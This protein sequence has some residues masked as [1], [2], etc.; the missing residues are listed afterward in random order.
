MAKKTPRTPKAPQG[1][2]QG[3]QK[4]ATR[5][6]NKHSLSK[7][8]NGFRILGSALT[9]PDDASIALMHPA[10]M[11]QCQFRFEASVL[12]TS[13]SDITAV[14]HFRVVP[15]RAVTCGRICF[16]GAE[17]DAV[18]VVQTAPAPPALVSI[19]I[20]SAWTDDYYKRYVHWTLRQRVVTQGQVLVV[21]RNMDEVAL[22]LTAP[23]HPGPAVITHDTRVILVSDAS[24]APLDPDYIGDIE[25][26]V[27]LVRLTFTSA[28]LNPD[29]IPA[30]SVVH[31]LPGTGKTLISRHLAKLMGC[32]LL[33]VTNDQRHPAGLRQVLD[34]AIVQAPALVFIDEIDSLGSSESE[35]IVSM[36]PATKTQQVFIL[37]ATNRHDSVNSRL[38]TAI[39]SDFEVGVPSEETRGAML[40]HFLSNL[41]IVR[42][43]SGMLLVGPPGSGKARLARHVG[44][45]LG[46]EVRVLCGSA[47]VHSDNPCAMVLDFFRQAGR[48]VL[49]YISELEALCPVRSGDSDAESV[50]LTNTMLTSLQQS[51]LPVICGA[52]N[53]DDLDP[54]VRRFGRLD[55]EILIPPLTEEDRALV[56]QDMLGTLPLD[57]DVSA[58]VG[59][60]PGFLRGDLACLVR[61]AIAS[62]KHLTSS[63]LATRAA[64]VSPAAR[65]STF[66]LP[67]GLTFAA[68]AGYGSAIAQLKESVLLSTARR[69]AFK[70]MKL[71]PARGVMIHGANGVGKTYMATALA[72]ESGRTP[73]AIR[74]PDILS[75]FLGETERKLVKLF[76]AA[77]QAVPSVILIDEIDAIASSRSDRTGNLGTRILTT[78][79][80]LIDGVDSAADLLVVGTTSRPAVIDPAL[81]RSGRLGVTVHIGLPS[82][83]DL[84]DLCYYHLRPLS[85]TIE[86]LEPLCAEFAKAY[87]G[88]RCT[89]SDVKLYCQHVKEKLALSGRVE[90]VD[91]VT[92]VMASLT[93]SGTADAG[94]IAMSAEFESGKG[95]DTSW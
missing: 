62:G 38:R 25:D 24:P 2:F 69:A 17:D 5:T 61:D 95:G 52:T 32:A 51:R 81:R 19:S 9:R 57:G 49:L 41:T 83:E 53:S 88:T 82:E 13:S 42:P 64:K 80:T 75:P 12:I 33:T 44:M 21:P 11:M 22:T 20:V 45:T 76:K 68:V 8:G 63:A 90:T 29:F 92:E 31:G 16:P 7:V 73:F 3:P 10:D 86:G 89:A 15:D 59:A 35:E 79:L 6:P 30:G 65:W 40:D 77:R 70:T 84:R 46:L 55:E 91:A 36:I 94:L 54:A 87:T 47:V 50:L 43:P 39:G 37:G 4:S 85:V 71:K 78:L 26:L 14:W 60:T 58:V 93:C 74:G 28:G 66:D 67:R 34:D 18:Y 23:S 48:G 72:A 56:L 27:R 1:H